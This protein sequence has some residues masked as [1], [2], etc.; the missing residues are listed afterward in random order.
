MPSDTPDIHATRSYWSAK[1]EEWVGLA[2]TVAPTADRFNDPLLA[3]TGIA[4]GQIV[5]DLA[6]GAGE[7]ALTLKHRVQPDGLVIASDLAHAMLTG[8]RTRD[9]GADLPMV[10]AD[11]QRLPFA[12]ASFDRVVCRF[13]IMFVPDPMAALGV[14]KSVLKPGGRVGFAVWDTRDDQTMFCALAAAMEKAM[15][16]HADAHHMQIF[17]FAGEGS[18]ARLMEDA[19]FSDISDEAHGYTA[20][21]PLDKPFWRPQLAMTFGHEIR[22]ASPE[23]RQA[24]E[25]AVKAWLDENARGA[26]GYELATQCRVVTGRA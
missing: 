14:I 4:P 7:P 19:G 15:G 24:V 9:G 1:A 17:R 26:Q 21:A 25:E 16:I 10:A 2:Q 6:S 22:S 20:R 5:L 13:G 3:A 12:A 11:M 18:L 8:I 23:D